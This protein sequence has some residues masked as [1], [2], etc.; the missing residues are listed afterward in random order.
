[1]PRARSG[2]LDDTAAVK[3]RSIQP[4]QQRIS[5]EKRRVILK[6]SI[7]AFL[8]NGYQATRMDS[9]GDRAGVSYAT[10]YKHFP[11]KEELFLATLDH[12]CARLFERWKSLAVPEDVEGGLNAIGRN[13][14]AA[15]SDP[16]LV[17]T[18][19][20]IIGQVNELPEA[21]ERLLKDRAM[22]SDVTD[23]WLRARVRDQKL[24]IANVPLARAE[25]IGMLS[26]AFLMPRLLIPKYESNPSVV[27]KTIGSIVETFLARYQPT[28]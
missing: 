12:V 8:A 6:A 27:R 4:H 9:I 3:S 5:N 2:Q 10:L 17:A 19:R 7:E 15:V 1:M 14:L 28:R 23:E 11:S 20:M 25:F 13:Y 21:G 16:D 24:N 26:E 18:M 22:F